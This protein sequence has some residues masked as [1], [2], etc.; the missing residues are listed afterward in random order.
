MNECAS[1]IS[2]YPG[3]LHMQ[4]RRLGSSSRTAALGR[5]QPFDG[6]IDQVRI[7]DRK[8]TTDVRLTAGRT[9]VHADGTINDPADEDRTYRSKSYPKVRPR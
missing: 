6:L 7:Y 8:L 2:R 4:D 5:K 1:D 9:A 3:Y